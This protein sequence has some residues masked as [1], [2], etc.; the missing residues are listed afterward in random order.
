MQE[1]SRYR[2]YLNLFI[3]IFMSP[4]L[5]AGSPT[6]PHNQEE[7]WD[8]E[9]PKL[10]KLEGED[11]TDAVNRSD[12][13]P[14]LSGFSDPLGANPLWDDSDLDPPP[15]FPG[16]GGSGFSHYHPLPLPLP[17][18]PPA[19][20][21]VEPLPPE[22][23]AEGSPE[24]VARRAMPE[25]AWL[26]VVCD[27]D[28]TFIYG[29]TGTNEVRPYGMQLLNYLGFFEDIELVVWTAGQRYYALGLLRTIAAQMERAGHRLRVH[30]LIVAGPWMR[31]PP[32]SAY[33]KNVRLLNRAHALMIENNHHIASNTG[34]PTLLL[35]DFV[36]NMPHDQ[37]LHTVSYLVYWLVDVARRVFAEGQ[38][39]PADHV[40][41]ILFDREL[42]NYLAQEGYQLLLLVTGPRLEDL[43]R[44][45]APRRPRPQEEAP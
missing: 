7:G 34:V 14:A 36:G 5:Y 8:P 32:G 26:T 27:L 29:R 19:I 10:E 17:I 37:V 18:A 2:K 33:V 41:R 12:A 13:N 31:Q 40:V 39:L 22:I 1:S 23:L 38:A 6:T 9:V 28:E 16:G 4:W 3:L 25:G 44:I 24:Q 11:R 30:Q 45:G 43:L 35:P 20:D 42:H 21:A 15:F